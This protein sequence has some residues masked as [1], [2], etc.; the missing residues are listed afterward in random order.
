MRSFKDIPK[1]VILYHIIPKWRCQNV[2]E[3]LKKQLIN[4]EIRNEF[5]LT[6][7]DVLNFEIYYFETYTNS[8]IG[9]QNIFYEDVI[10]IIDK[11][12]DSGYF[13]LVENISIMT[14]IDVCSRSRNT[15]LMGDINLR[16]YYCG[17]TTNELTKHLYNATNI[18]KLKLAKYLKKWRKKNSLS[19]IRKIYKII[20]NR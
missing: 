9:K 6:S 14:K 4:L 10:K 17:E 7:S 13:V 1:D 11:L 15:I 3:T 12:I 18:N 8:K 5:C 16:S 20:F 2:F 19:H